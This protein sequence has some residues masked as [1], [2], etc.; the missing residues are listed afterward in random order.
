MDRSRL[1]RKNIPMKIFPKTRPFEFIT[2]YLLGSLTKTKTDL[3][4]ILVIVSRFS[5]LTQVVPLLLIDAYF[6]F[7]EHWMFSYGVSRTVLFD[8]GSQLAS[9]LFQGM[10]QVMGISNLYTSTYH[11]Q[12]NGQTEKYNGT[13]SPMI[14]CYIFF[15][16][17]D[18]E[19]YIGVLKQPYNKN[20]Y[21][22][23]G[24]SLLVCPISCRTMILWLMRQNSTEKNT[25]IS[26]FR[27][28]NSSVCV[29]FK[30]AHCKL[31]S[32]TLFYCED[33]LRKL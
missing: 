14:R 33:H 26:F 19:K 28:V 5:K 8:N 31:V 18:R 13:I 4:Y 10:L 6:A 17:R 16:Q 29:H 22:R 9:K 15:H 25:P 27:T 1:K 32:I 30:A 2:L 23:T 20:M 11:S 3:H 12:I 21:R 7:A 24:D